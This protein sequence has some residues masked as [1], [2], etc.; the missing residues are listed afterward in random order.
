MKIFTLPMF[1]L[2][3]V[4]MYMCGVVFAEVRRT[5]TNMENAL[6]MMIK[7]AT[8]H[9]YNSNV[10]E[11]FHIYHQLLHVHLM[12]RESNPLFYQSDGESNKE[13]KQLFATALYE[14][15][16]LYL[17]DPEESSVSKIQSSLFYLLQS[18]DWGNSD[19]M[20]VLAS[21][22]ATGIYAGHS[23]MPMD[24]TRSVILDFMASLSGNPEANMA[25]G[26]RYLRGIGVKENCEIA[27]KH[28]EFA[29][30]AAS[31]Q[32]LNYTFAP[33]VEKSKIT[34]IENMNSR[35]RREIDPEI[36]DYYKHLAEEGDVNAALS[37]ASVYTHGSRYIDQNIPLATYYLDLVA[38]FSTVGSGQLG[39]ILAQV[40][41]KNIALLSKLRIWKKDENTL[42]LMADRIVRL[43]RWSATRGEIFG[44][45]GLGFLH[46]KGIGLE[47]NEV[48]AHEYFKKVAG[49]HPDAYFYMAEILVGVGLSDPSLG[50]ERSV[51]TDVA[52]AAVNYATASQRGH[53]I[54]THRLG[55]MA[56]M[57]LGITRSCPTAVNSFKVI[58]ERGEWMREL[59]KAYRLA[60]K[61]SVLAALS[62]FA[63][64]A[65]MGVE[66]AQFNAAHILQKLNKCPPVLKVSNASHDWL[67]DS[68]A[69]NK[70]ENEDLIP[71]VRLESEPSLSFTGI[72]AAIAKAEC[73]MRAYALYGLSA[74][75]SDGE[76]LLRLGDF[77]YYGFAGLTI[78]KGE[79]AVFYQLAADLKHT[80]AI[81]N[82]GMM[83]EAGDGVPQDF[84]LAKRYF[85]YAAEVDFDAK[86]PRAIA[87][88][89]LQ[90][91][92]MLQGVL[93]AEF[94]SAVATYFT[95][96][97]SSH[98]G[99][100]K[101][102]IDYFLSWKNSLL[103]MVM[104]KIVIPFVEYN[105]YFH[106]FFQRINDGVTR[107][108][109]VRNDDDTTAHAERQVIP[110]VREKDFYLIKDHIS[111]YMTLVC[112]MLF[113]YVFMYKQQ[114]RE[115]I[116]ERRLNNGNVGI[117]NNR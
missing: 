21:S 10:K 27:L 14:L 90:A 41:D 36:V 1:L 104:R 96:T 37:L 44:V 28:Y 40:Y 82:L 99:V 114:R 75:Q 112:G 48:K 50:P 49:K 102:H 95:P 108:L 43:L 20:R 16:L 34:D 106:K 85:D 55:H 5:T 15:S 80:H 9:K 72:D 53:V 77:H 32:L 12:D 58:A 45:L 6:K 39:Y 97:S 30:N 61:G 101:G 33:Y 22:Y 68:F 8:D 19:A 67:A 70:K 103:Q 64:Y 117:V 91:Y 63:K 93:G 7:A 23:L 66:S 116:V 86:M 65:S 56:A 52:G 87:M 57:G 81:F 3:L 98:I 110:P 113:L 69:T 35:G 11:S 115:R 51:R 59:T 79:A 60:E 4:N 42:P 84:H 24:A 89:L 47:K 94:V 13:R 17:Y 71:A 109:G 31:Q 78:D 73:D 74:Y 100:I 83:H 54:A 46:M 26:Y 29:A 111:L 107:L 38:D 92:Q 18:A 105:M 2:L 62:I 88:F 25:M 76:A